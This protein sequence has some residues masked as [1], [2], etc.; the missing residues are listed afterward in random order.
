MACLLLLFGGGGWIASAVD[1]GSRAA[2]ADAR[3]AV[4][5]GKPASMARPGV[6]RALVYEV[7]V[8]PV[9]SWAAL[10][11]GLPEENDIL[12]EHRLNVAREVTIA[13]AALV[14]ALAAAVLWLDAW[15][16]FRAER[17]GRPD[18]ARVEQGD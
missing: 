1:A 15:R 3:E 6:V 4:L 14:Y 17:Q 7:G 5:K 12:F 11:V 2:L 13:G 8:N 9:R 10:S 16:C 18:R